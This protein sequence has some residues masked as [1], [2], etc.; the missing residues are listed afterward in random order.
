[1][2][3][4]FFAFLFAFVSCSDERNI[5]NSIDPNANISNL[6][7]YNWNEVYYHGSIT[8]IRKNNLPVTGF[9]LSYDKDGALNREEYYVNGYQEGVENH[10][11]KDGSL[12]R[13]ACFRNGEKHG[14]VNGWYPNGRKSYQRFYINGN[15]DGKQIEWYENGQLKLISNYN[16][17]L[18]TGWQKAY[19]ENGDVLY[20]VNLINGNGTISYQSINNV[21]VTEVY[22]F[23]VE[24][25]PIDG[26]KLRS[27]GRKE[28]GFRKPQPRVK[29][30]EAYDEN[31]LRHGK[32]YSAFENGQKSFEGE[33]FFDQEDGIHQSWYE[34]GKLKEIKKYN[35]G[36]LM[37]AKCW[38]ESGKEME[39]D[40]YDN[41]GKKIK[42][43]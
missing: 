2:R 4:F 6:N 7:K 20:Q 19:L 41:S 40:C 18:R 37:S 12:E 25:S 28:G 3:Y 17:G 16:N 26:S 42:C 1:M 13:E 24:V 9:V 31:G 11:Y 5:P 14:S 8:L 36:I 30:S 23:G 34:N 29:G 21:Q 15:C 33:Y 27:G 32:D 43:P 10:Y 35:K 22:T 38:D 39:C